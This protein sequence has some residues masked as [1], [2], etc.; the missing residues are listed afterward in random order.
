MHHLTNPTEMARVPAVRAV[1]IRMVP[2]S[3]AVSP[4]SGV[5]SGADSNASPTNHSEAAKPNLTRATVVTPIATSPA[6]ATPAPN[7][8][9][10]SIAPLPKVDAPRLP[11]SLPSFPSL[12]TVPSNLRIATGTGP[13]GASKSATSDA[14]TKVSLSEPTKSAGDGVSI[15]L[16]PSDAKPTK[17]VLPAMVIAQRDTPVDSPISSKPNSSKPIVVA[18]GE[19]ST[20][21]PKTGSTA[22]IQNEFA[23]PSQRQGALAQPSLH[24]MVAEAAS[25][26]ATKVIPTGGSAAQ[27]RQPEWIRPKPVR[28]ISASAIVR[29]DES[30]LTRHTSE[31][32][33]VSNQ[34]S[35]LPH[36]ANAAG[37]ASLGPAVVAAVSPTLQGPVPSV[38]VD[39][40]PPTRLE[41]R[42]ATPKQPQV[43]STQSAK[44]HLAAPKIASSVALPPSGISTALASPQIAGSPATN[45]PD[46]GD[47]KDNL[48]AKPS[49]ESSIAANSQGG[50][51]SMPQ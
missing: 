24:A 30:S 37:T 4:I 41:E 48:S 18:V 50:E 20:G 10:Q 49:V 45:G 17:A 13:A 31:P 43:A 12:P 51:F 7:F 38:M 25:T 42:P 35:R 40:A 23:T 8:A 19:P 2:G 6:S 9:V 22:T 32:S 1:G 39:I 46:V 28:A 14:G 27:S 33:A 34:D 21:A 16:I 3:N 11:P 44:T 26:A 47:P 29:L 5:Q 15:R 36:D